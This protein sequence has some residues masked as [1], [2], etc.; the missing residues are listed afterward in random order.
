[1]EYEAGHTLILAHARAYRLY[2]RMYR[3]TQNGKFCVGLLCTPVRS[4][5]RC[6]K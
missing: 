5:K 2:D 1:M 6:L 3:Q 4:R